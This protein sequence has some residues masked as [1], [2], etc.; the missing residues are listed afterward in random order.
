MSA[1][2]VSGQ[3]Q[4]AVGNWAEMSQGEIMA[5]TLRAQSGHSQ[6]QLAGKLLC[7]PRGAVTPNQWQ[8]SVSWLMKDCVES[9][10]CKTLQLMPTK[11]VRIL[12]LAV[13]VSVIISINSSMS[14][15]QQTFV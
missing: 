6:G 12:L 11:V 14:H 5:A 13:T 4:A 7:G 9:C 10:Q 1:A 2:V 15:P 8:L 3:W